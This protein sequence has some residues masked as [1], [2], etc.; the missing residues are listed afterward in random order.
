MVV[1]S[2]AVFLALI[3]SASGAVAQLNTPPVLD[4]P[5]QT[6]RVPA[7]I[8]GGRALLIPLT[9]SDA[10][11]DRLTYTVRSS[12]AHVQARV[13]TGNPFLRFTVNHADGG[14]GDPAYSGD[15]IFMLLR[16]W[17][18]ITSGFIGGFAQSGFY[19]GTV[20]HRLT[21]LGAENTGFIFQGGDPLGNG[22]GGPGMTGAPLNPNTSWKFDNE[23]DPGL[24][25][26]GRGQLAMANAGT[27]VRLFGSAAV[28][29]F[30]DSNGSQ[31]F[32]TE[33][34]LRALDFKHT[35]FAQLVRG[36]ELLPLLRATKTTGTAPDVAVT[37]AGATVR[38]T[39]GPNQTDAVLVLSATAAGPAVITVTVSDRR[40]GTATKTFTATA[41]K[42]TINS[43]PFLR[44]IA[45]LV[46]SKGAD[47]FFKLQ[48]VDLEHDFIQTQ[49]FVVQGFPSGGATS[50]G[51]DAGLRPAAGDDGLVSMGFVT[52]QFSVGAQAFTAL[53][54]ATNASIGV[55]DRIAQGERV[56]V[57]GAPGVAFTGVAGKIRDFDPA[58]APADFTATINWG[59]GTPLDT[60]AIAVDSS[61]P[62]AS[63]LAV[64]GTHTYARAGIYPVVVNFAGGKGV[65]GVAR[66]Q[67]VITATALRAV[68]EGLEIPGA[69]LRNPI[70]ATFSDA[71][72]NGNP[73][74]YAA[75]VD[76]GDGVITDGVVA[77]GASGRF[78]VRGTHTYRDSE[79]YAVHVRI[80]RRSD[81]PGLNEVSAWTHAT[82]S[83]RTAPHLPPFPKPNL[84]AAWQS[85]LQKT[86]AGTPGPAYSVQIASS[87]IAI[88]SGN[89]TMPLCTIRYWLSDDQVLSKTTD[90]AVLARIQGAT[91]FSPQ[92]T[93]SNFAPGAST[94]T[95]GVTLLLPRGQSGGRKYIVTELAYNDPLTNVEA[96]DKSFASREVIVPL[97]VIR[98][99][100]VPSTTE[101]GGTATFTVQ[102]DTAPTT[103]VTIPLVSS[104]PAEGTVSPSQLVFTAANWD[105]PQTVT[106][107]G[108]DDA[109]KDGLKAYVI[110]LTPATSTDP[111]YSGFNAPDV[112]FTNQDNEP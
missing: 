22:Q 53:N 82:P 18:P 12:K 47:V 63:L 8:P 46:T 102:L 14:A 66:G 84:T 86:A 90:L 89:R 44:K 30:K 58:S 19:D 112:N 40:G 100:A 51:V 31:F 50:G 96:I 5:I 41:V 36:W 73:A 105:V 11:G 94:Q 104:V 29:D 69:V 65:Q 99:P 42:D 68:G 103:D 97:A 64:S 17:A 28:G 37:L 34:P 107:T 1:P 55:G 6:D 32:L 79:G 110:Q 70:L 9:A 15:L 75:Q 38:P 60:G 106:A 83:F 33:S 74:D 20:F 27:N 49:H 2:R 56:I 54:L 16:D 111:L 39:S 98:G 21:A 101:S 77:R 91:A 43:P 108:A 80:R 67:A 61:A 85:V 62:G 7:T 52:N 59:D 81:P 10:D 72:S 76:W 4:D 57:E 88:N 3:L 71:A 87:F 23:L 95:V 45:P 109:V 24:I 35:I 25:F 93:L 48:P 78:L 92:L 26:V 13:K